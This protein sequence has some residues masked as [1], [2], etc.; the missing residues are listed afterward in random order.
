MGERKPVTQDRTVSLSQLAHHA[1]ILHLLHLGAY[2]IHHCGRWLGYVLTS[3]TGLGCIPAAL[4]S[5]TVILKVYHC[6]HN[7]CH[8]VGAS[9]R[10]HRVVTV[11]FFTVW[12][13]GD[14]RG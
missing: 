3:C 8:K 2:Q 14:G 1:N 4:V 12:F 13:C 6:H 11:V 5:A 10:L 9:V 7:A